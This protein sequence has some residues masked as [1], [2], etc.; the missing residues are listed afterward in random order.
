MTAFIL[1]PSNRE[2]DIAR[3]A[4]M[5]RTCFPGKPVKVEIDIDRPERSPEQLGAMFGLAYKV[6]MAE[7]GLRGDKDR[8]KLHRD[9]CGEYFGWRTVKVMG[10][11]WKEPAR[12]TSRDEN[13]K[14]VAFSNA[15]QAEF[16][17]FIEQRAAEFGI[18]IPAPD[19]RWK[20]NTS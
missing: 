2:P 14:R 15:E 3:L 1:K 4:V 10:K 8:K 5:L 19:P 16:Y 20:E 12:T 6:I 18:V 13:G 17:G 9:F 11:T 7:T